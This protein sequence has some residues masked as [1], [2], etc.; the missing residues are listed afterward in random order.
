MIAMIQTKY[1]RL[2]CRFF[3]AFLFLAISSLLFFS[4]NSFQKE[5][6]YVIGFSQCTGGDYWRKTMLAE[7]KREL[8]FH[9]N[10][11]FLYKE[12]DDNSL[13]QIQQVK[14][15]QESK[16]DLL[17]ISPNEALPLT[18]IVEEVITKASR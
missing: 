14:E 3:C 5:K 8:A 18:P 11:K 4:C 12:A 1:V 6:T 7:M 17:I 15:L 13:K 16:I 10:I 2:K 9:E